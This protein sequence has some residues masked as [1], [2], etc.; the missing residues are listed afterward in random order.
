MAVVLRGGRQMW[1]NMKANGDWGTQ[2]NGEG[3]RT[4]AREG[5]KHC[6][7]IRERKFERILRTLMCQSQV[8]TDLYWQ[9]AYVS[10][11]FF[12]SRCTLQRFQTVCTQAGPRLHYSNSNV[13]RFIKLLKVRLMHGE[14][15][16]TKISITKGQFFPDSLVTIFWCVPAVLRWIKTSPGPRKYL[17]LV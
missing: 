2:S 10:F 6:D 8:N 16:I 17:R 11:F 7:M 4:K 5:G 14:D 1:S 3:K 9:K 13:K 12:C 15:E